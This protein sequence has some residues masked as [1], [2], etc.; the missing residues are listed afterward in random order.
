MKTYSPYLR[1][2]HGTPLDSRVEARMALYDDES[3]EYVLKSDYDTVTRKLEVLSAPLPKLEMNDLTLSYFGVHG[4]SPEHTRIYWDRILSV[5]MEDPMVALIAAAM[6]AQA[7]R[8]LPMET[9]PKDGTTILAHDGTTTYPVFW[10][11]DPLLVHAEWGHHQWCLPGSVDLEEGR[12]EPM[13]ANPLGWQPLP[14]PP[15]AP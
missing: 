4:H 6:V 9:A 1:A 5:K 7:P 2:V 12:Y 10:Q 11:R 3:G 13:A 14:K 15:A 8:W